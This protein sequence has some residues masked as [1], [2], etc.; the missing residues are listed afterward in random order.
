MNKKKRF[1]WWRRQSFAR[2]IT[3]T[4]LIL[5]LVVVVFLM[6]FSTQYLTRIVENKILEFSHNALHQSSLNIAT[7]LKG[8][9]D[10]VNQMIIDEKFL[11]YVNAL[12][13]DDKTQATSPQIANAKQGLLASMKTFMAYRPMVRSMSVQTEKGDS[14]SYDKLLIESIY[15]QVSPIHE[16]YFNE[17][18]TQKETDGKEIWKTAQYFDQQG[19]TQYY[20]FS[21]RKKL[22]NWYEKKE[23]GAFIMSINEAALADICWE[24][25]ISEKISD[26]YVFIIDSEGTIVSHYNKELIGKSLKQAYPLHEQEAYKQRSGIKKMGQEWVDYDP[27]DGTDWTM[28]GVLNNQYIFGKLNDFRYWAIGISMLVAAVMAFLIYYVSRQISKSVKTVVHTMN[29]VEEGILSAKIKVKKEDRNEITL[30][31]ARFNTMMSKINEQM[32]LIR[33]ADQREKELEMRALEAQINPHFIYN[34]LDCIHWM[35]LDNGEE[36]ISQMLSEFAQIFR[37]QIND[38]NGLVP[39]RE[40]IIYLKKY[41]FLQKVRFSDSFEYVVSCDEL[42]MDNKIHKMIFQPLI[43]NAIIH[44]YSNIHYGGFLKIQISEY[45]ETHLVFEISDN[46]KGMKQEQ[47]DQVFYSSNPNTKSIGVNNVLSRLDVYYGKEYQLEITSGEG[48]GTRLLIR[49]PKE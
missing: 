17:L 41:L 42:V 40:E 4:Y 19:T 6:G 37:Y 8:Y 14:F 18:F 23:V 34:T 13:S 39:I 49:I 11:G 31:A 48:R 1:D 28:I 20:L 21:F 12:E 16:T 5:F 32:E 29:E 36:E 15:Q 43:E 45:D 24:A 22:F 35:A 44:G 27:I 46:G 7:T 9:E 25:Q 47:I 10:S 2:Q 30:I 3:I 33:S 26:N 38:S